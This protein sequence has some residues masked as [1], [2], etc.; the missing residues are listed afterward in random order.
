MRDES[1]T[2]LILFVLISVFARTG[3]AQSHFVPLNP[4]S[5]EVAA[6]LVDQILNNTL[7][8][9]LS[10]EPEGDLELQQFWRGNIPKLEA[11][12][13]GFEV[14]YEAERE[15]DPTVTVRARPPFQLTFQSSPQ[16]VIVRHTRTSE[17]SLRGGVRFE[18][19]TEKRRAAFVPGP[20]ENGLAIAI[21]R[22]SIPTLTA[23]LVCPRW[24]NAPGGRIVH[25][26]LQEVPYRA[27]SVHSKVWGRVRGQL[28]TGHLLGSARSILLTTSDVPPA[29]LPTDQVTQNDPLV[30]SRYRASA[31]LAA[32]FGVLAPYSGVRA[33]L[34]L[35][36]QAGLRRFA[37]AEDVVWVRSVPLTRR[38]NV[39]FLGYDFEV[40]EGRCD[41]VYRQQFR[42]NSFDRSD[43]IPEQIQPFER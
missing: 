29:V 42:W 30:E 8:A 28:L 23:A 1:R 3:E 20:G 17:P 10:R 14:N 7:I 35:I 26:H 24:A 33:I 15:V 19:R 2:L 13:L 41:L 12:I 38:F 43:P 21:G 36:T 6:G 16:E 34:E 4:I 27:T 32:P 18:A 37:Y 11:E 39:V 25:R 31:D 22:S 9:P 5:D 40:L